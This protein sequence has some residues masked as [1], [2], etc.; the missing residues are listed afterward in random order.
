MKRWHIISK[1]FVPT[2]GL[3]A[4]AMLATSA[5]G[6]LVHLGLGKLI[7]TPV[8]SDVS[9]SFG[10]LPLMNL[11]NLAQPEP[12]ED[13]SF[14]L[15]MLAGMIFLFITAWASLKGDF[16][17]SAARMSFIAAI[18]LATAGATAWG[19]N[20]FGS[21]R[22][23][24]IAG[25][26]LQSVQ[27][28]PIS[29]IFLSLIFASFIAIIAML[30]A[31]GKWKLVPAGFASIPLLLLARLSVLGNDDN[32][33]IN[34]HYE[35]FVYPLIQDW[36]GDGI[37]LGS[38]GQKSQYGLYPIFLRPI[39]HL[40]GGPSTVAITAVM[41]AL[42]LISFLCTLAYITRFTKHP[43][44]AAVL[45][46]AAIMGGTLV[47]PWW[48]VDPYFQVFPVRL[49]FPSIAL[50]LLC[51]QKSR[52]K[53]RFLSYLLLS[54]GLPWNFESGIIGLGTYSVFI[55]GANFSRHN[56][57][58]V[59]L[60]QALLAAGAVA[61]TVVGIIAYYLVRFG[62]VPDLEGPVASIHLFAAGVGALPMPAFG[63]W[64]LH[65]LVYG[66]AIFV[67]LRSLW[68][69]VDL[70]GRNR[71]AALL[72][73]AA[74]GIVWFRYYQG[75][76]APNQLQLV[77]LPAFCCAALLLDRAVSGISSSTRAVAAIL[78]AAVGAP[79]VA[80]LAVW[81]LGTNT[82]MRPI[83]SI[84]N[85]SHPDAARNRLSEKIIETL[86]QVKQNE[87]DELLVLSPYA[88]LVN[89][90]RGRPSPVHT[91]GMCQIWLESEL[92]S[93]LRLV[94]N[95]T[96]RMVVVDR[97]KSCLP[98][99]NLRELEPRLG[100]LLLREFDELNIPFDYCGDQAP[101]FLIRKGTPLDR[102]PAK[103]N[104]IN[105]AVGKPVRESSTLKGSSP[106][107]AVDGN[108][109]GVFSSGSTSHTDLQS[110]P[111][112]E[113]DLGDEKDVNSIEI[114][115][116]T[117]CCGERLRNFWVLASNERLPGDSSAASLA[118][119]HDVH[120]EFRSSSP[121][122]MTR[123]RA[124]FRARFVRIQLDETGYLSL[125]EV[126]VFGE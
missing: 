28:Y 82:P 78:S 107:A 126:R 47:F 46:L 45:T 24:R 19:V 6:V 15:T 16:S 89:L 97:S 30:P 8:A 4:I 72:A 80:A 70:E 73:M 10:I 3:F 95:P 1:D 104:L 7:T 5:F 26:V 66:I 55:V 90:E 49:L 85:S 108:V 53:H 113:V 27:D 14:I 105:L 109:D 52:E 67:G 118:K 93:V 120:S 117:D 111:W 69:E 35:V 38:D 32:Y 63:A 22:T 17:R 57:I 125:A 112:W 33:A 20:I 21:P 54:I 96:T 119:R 116:R 60:R 61:V 12:I 29:F 41:A 88:Y 114:W 56:V 83:A 91:A 51:W 34:G 65:C 71:S 40:S 37:Y 23:F 44:L 100:A 13:I 123:I 106:T 25:F 50:A 99:Q 98:L 39:W 18:V 84:T 76:S 101:R 36:L 59:A 42:L 64:G 68:S 75:R 48:P 110:G 81:L 92:Q 58:R 86:K 77:S 122:R 31:E 115:N 94:S 87:R 74:A 124:S 2:V 103:D 79:L 9:S 11:Y 43:A 121:C 62:T 102:L